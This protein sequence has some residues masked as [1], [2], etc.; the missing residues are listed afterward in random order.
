[1]NDLRQYVRRTK[2]ELMICLGFA[3]L[4]PYMV[5]Q[6]ISMLGTES[7]IN[8]GTPLNLIFFGSFLLTT[9]GFYKLWMEDN[10]PPWA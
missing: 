6:M 10:R 3:F 7:F 9:Y 2:N 5:L 8:F 4:A 1:M